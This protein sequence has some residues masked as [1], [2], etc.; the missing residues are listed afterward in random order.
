MELQAALV[1]AVFANE[2]TLPTDDEMNSEIR[3][4]KKRLNYNNPML[5]DSETYMN[6][7]QLLLDTRKSIG[8]NEQYDEMN[9][10]GKGTSE[11]VTKSTE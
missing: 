9:Q 6:E 8:F 11:E 7:L 2:I 3:N 4:W 10:R 5:V 1:S